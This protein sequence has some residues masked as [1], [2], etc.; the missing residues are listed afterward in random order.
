VEIRK[1]DATSVDADL[2]LEFPGLHLK[3]TATFAKATP[4]KGDTEPAR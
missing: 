4:D 2:D 3:K 1:V